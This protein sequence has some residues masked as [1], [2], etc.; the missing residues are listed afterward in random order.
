[1]SMEHYCKRQFLHIHNQALRLPL[2]ETPHRRLTKFFAPL[3]HA[4]FQHLCENL[5]VSVND[6]TGFWSQDLQAFYGIQVK[7]LKIPFHPRHIK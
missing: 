7:P 4:K 3:K 2:S 5:V 6:P 1:M